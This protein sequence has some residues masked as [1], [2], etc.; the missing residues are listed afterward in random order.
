MDDLQAYG[1]DDDW[2][3]LWHE[4]DRADL[5]PGRVVTDRGSHLKVVTPHEYDAEIAGKLSHTARSHEL[6]KIGGLG[7]PASRSR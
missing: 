1:W 2:A 5:M 3:Q 6:P 7:R 4:L